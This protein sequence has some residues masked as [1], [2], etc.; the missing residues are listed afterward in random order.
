MFI[1]FTI[2]ANLLCDSWPAVHISILQYRCERYSGTHFTKSATE[3]LGQCFVTEPG[4]GKRNPLRLRHLFEKN[5]VSML[6]P[7]LSVKAK[8]QH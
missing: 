1:Y 5:K 2:Y 3:T 7:H 4:L 8:L 6:L